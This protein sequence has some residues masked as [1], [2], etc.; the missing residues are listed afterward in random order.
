M[1]ADGRELYF[2]SARPGGKGKLDLWLSRNDG[3]RWQEPV[4]LSLLNTADDE[5][6]PAL[7]PDGRELWFYRNYG[8][9]R[10]LKTG[11][12]WGAP[13]QIL[14]NLAGEPS[15]DLAGNLYFVHHYFVDGKMIEADLYVAYRK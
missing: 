14:S 11:G 10:S 8:I 5:G 12:D 7:S 3:G 2:G 15:L 6:W 13:E 1:S 4:N 9:W